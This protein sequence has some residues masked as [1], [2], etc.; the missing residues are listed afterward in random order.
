MDPNNFDLYTLTVKKLRSLPKFGEAISH[1]FQRT[2]EKKIS[3]QKR[4]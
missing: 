4:K 2:E 3:A 1:F